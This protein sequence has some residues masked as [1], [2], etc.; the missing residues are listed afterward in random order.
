MLVQCWASVVDGGPTLDQHRVDVP[1]LLGYDYQLLLFVSSHASVPFSGVRYVQCL[2][3]EDA[4]PSRRFFIFIIYLLCTSL[5]GLH[6]LSLFLFLW[7]L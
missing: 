1:C 3:A 2:V 4:R 6:N 5:Y 7:N